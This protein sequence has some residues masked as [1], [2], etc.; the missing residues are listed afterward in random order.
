VYDPTAKT[1]KV[2]LENLYFPNGIQVSP[3]QQ[4]IYIAETNICR[5]GRYHLKGDKTGRYEIV[6]DGLPGN[7]D[8][9]KFNSEGHL[10]VPFPVFRTEFTEKLLSSL[11]VRKLLSWVPESLMKLFINP[12]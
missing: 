4:T 5:L 7:P 6:L 8:N 11:F 12:K 10:W 3:D 2:L 9:I 1:T